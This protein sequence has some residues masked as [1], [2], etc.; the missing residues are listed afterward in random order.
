MGD[1]PN[2]PQAKP[3]PTPAQ[4]LDAVAKMAE[5]MPLGCDRPVRELAVVLKDILK[6]S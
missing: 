3:A 6:L 4:R 1:T 2:Q 5:A